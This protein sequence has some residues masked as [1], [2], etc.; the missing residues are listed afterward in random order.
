MEVVDMKI[1]GWM[2]GDGWRWVAM[3]GDGWRW[4]AMGG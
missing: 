3:G 1:N 2:G 4:V